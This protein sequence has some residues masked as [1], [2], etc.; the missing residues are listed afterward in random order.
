MP[1]VHNTIRYVCVIQVSSF[2]TDPIYTIIDQLMSVQIG[3]SSL[4][5]TD[6]RSAPGTISFGKRGF[7]FFY[8]ALRVVKSL[9]REALDFLFTSFAPLAQ[10]PG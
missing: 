2:V 4:S 5:R 6:L 8:T 7:F 3:P 1:L 9:G 10:Q